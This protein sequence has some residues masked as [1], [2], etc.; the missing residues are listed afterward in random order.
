MQHNDVEECGMCEHS[1]QAASG[2]A[3][4]LMGKIRHGNDLVKN[5]NYHCIY[6]CIVWNTTV[7]SENI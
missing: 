1:V 4:E 5:M 2:S 6:D 3:A 7:Q